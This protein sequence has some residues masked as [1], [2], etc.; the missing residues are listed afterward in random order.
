MEHAGAKN[1]ILQFASD[2]TNDEWFEAK[3]KAIGEF[4]KHY[5]TEEHNE[6]F[7]GRSTPRS[8]STLRS[9]CSRIG[10]SG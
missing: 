1:L 8:T 5:V 6:H 9:S 2:S 3:F 10:D 4:A 7:P